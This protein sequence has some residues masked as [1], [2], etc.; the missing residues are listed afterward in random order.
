MVPVSRITR[1]HQINKYNFRTYIKYISKCMH[2]GSVSIA[3]SSL[4]TAAAPLLLSHSRCL[5]FC[6][7]YNEFLVFYL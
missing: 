4:P 1:T 2:G 5:C 3:W 6:Y 7:W